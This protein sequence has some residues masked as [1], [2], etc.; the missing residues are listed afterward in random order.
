MAGNPP[1]FKPEDAAFRLLREG[2][3][4]GFNRYKASG[5]EMDLT[6]CDFRGVDFRGIEAAGLDLSGCYFRQADLRG[7]DF[8]QAVLEGASING[9]LISGTYFPPELTAEEIDLSL[10]HGT[11]M[12]YSKS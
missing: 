3:I 10:M 12:R 5:G 8:S 9:A 1:K 11:R 7:V 4:E 6:H 2:D